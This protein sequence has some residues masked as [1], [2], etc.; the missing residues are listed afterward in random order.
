M[1][2]DVAR[3]RGLIPSLG[4]GWIHLDPQA[5]MQIPDAVSRTVSTAF[6]ASAPSPSGRHMSNRRSAA[7]LD[8]ARTAVADL[9]GG[10]PAGVVLG[11]DRAVLLA[12]LAESL[13]TRLGLGTGIVLSRLD[14][15]ANVSPWLRIAGRYGAAVRWAEVDI[16]TCEL[17]SWQFEE[18]ISSTTRLVALTAASPVVGTAPDVRAATDRVHEVGGLAVVDAN[19]AAPYAHIDLAELGADVVA[20]DG[21]SWGGPQA[22]AL[23]FRD[24]G[25]LDRIP[26]LSLDPFARGVE[27]LEIG[28]HQFAMLAGLTTSIDFLASLDESASGSRRERLEASISSLQHYHDTLFDHLLSALDRLPHVMLIGRATSRVP[29]ISFTIDGVAAD[30]VVTHLADR[31][32]ATLSAAHGGSRLL[33]SLGVNEAGGAVTIGLAPYTTRF[34][35]DQLVKE[36]AALG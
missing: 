6:R 33:D 27:R 36:L 16:E 10:D 14:D 13:S 4:D 35:I 30:K 11:A 29:A 8:S 17:P 19:G 34:E 31:R 18:L 25:M 15:E 7:V 5:G 20:V 2:Y 1:A 9:V 32:I 12:W 26:S 23:V 24:P 28:E 3:V 22:G 21:S